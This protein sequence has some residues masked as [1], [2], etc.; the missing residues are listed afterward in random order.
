MQAGAPAAIVSALHATED[1]SSLGV[2]YRGSWA[3]EMI[4]INKGQSNLPPSPPTT[5]YSLRSLFISPDYLIMRPDYSPLPQ[6]MLHAPVAMP[7]PWMRWK[8]S[9]GKGV[10]MPRG[11]REL[12]WS[13]CAADKMIG[14]DNTQSLIGPSN[15]IGLLI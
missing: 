3:L 15:C 7:V 2:M 11:R 5:T 10:R 14:R 6:P 8:R 9:R 4:A 12:R 1:G 13:R